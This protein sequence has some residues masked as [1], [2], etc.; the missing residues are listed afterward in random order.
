LS[1]IAASAGDIRDKFAAAD[2]QQRGYLDFAD[3]QT[4]VRLLKRRPDIEALVKTLTGGGTLVTQEQFVRFMRD[5][6][7]STAD[8]EVLVSLYAKFSDPD[9]GGMTTE[10][11]TSF[12]MSADN[13]VSTEHARVSMDMT[14]P[15]CEYFISSSH[16]VRADVAGH[17]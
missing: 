7:R 17:D 14:R 9:A 11:L 15:L 1:S 16:N 6:Q 5:E 4:F 13:T 12:L 10:G 3:F 8:D 2:V